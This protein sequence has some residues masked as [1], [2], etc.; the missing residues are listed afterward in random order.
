MFAIFKTADK[1]D[2]EIQHFVTNKEKLSPVGAKQHRYILEEFKRYTKVK[3]C[4]EITLD[5]IRSYSNRLVDRNTF[6]TNQRHME[7][8]RSFIRFHRH[9][10]IRPEWITAKGINEEAIALSQI[11]KEIIIYPMQV[12]RTNRKVER[13]RELVL[14]RKEDPRKWSIAKLGEHY[15]ITKRAVWEI[16]HRD[17][18]LYTR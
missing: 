11:E 12:L 3:S 2:I 4:E 6:F 5:H 14:K 18:E 16:W 13:N 9:F 1:I 15:G 8:L 10:Y 17:K 7:T